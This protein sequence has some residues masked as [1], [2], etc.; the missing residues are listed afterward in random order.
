[1]TSY[2]DTLQQQS[3][4]RWGGFRGSGSCQEAE[5]GCRAR[6]T[7]LLGLLA[8]LIAAVALGVQEVP[9]AVVDEAVRVLRGPA[10]L[11]TVHIAD[12]RGQDWT[13]RPS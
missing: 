4:L 1:M 6:L 10:A 13:L 2:T 9:A 7:L 5:E 8:L 12:M 11:G 3:E